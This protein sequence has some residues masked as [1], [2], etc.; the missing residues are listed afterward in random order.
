MTRGR[1]WERRHH[2]RFRRS[3][4]LRWRPLPSLGVPPEE[5]KTAV[6]GRIEN[7]SQGGLCLLSKRSIPQSS[8]VRCEIAVPGTRVAVPTLTQVRWTRRASPNHGYKI[9][10]QFLL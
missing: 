6:L 9:G 5:A 2:P 10:L 4:A 7:I 1:R 3:L 8:L